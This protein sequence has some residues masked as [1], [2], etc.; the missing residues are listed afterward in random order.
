M[1]RAVIQYFLL[2][3]SLFTPVSS[4]YG[5]SLPRPQIISIGVSGGSLTSLETLP[6]WEPLSVKFLVEAGYFTQHTRKQK[7]GRWTHYRC[8]KNCL[9][10][11]FGI[12]VGSFHLDKANTSYLHQTLGLYGRVGWLSGP[13]F[14]GARLGVSAIP[15]YSEAFGMQVTVGPELWVRLF[16]HLWLVVQVEYGLL[17]WFT[18]KPLP[19]HIFSL[20]GGLMFRI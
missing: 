3:G 6:G 18:S 17:G 1:K 10:Y 4:A 2:L 11:G 14:L 8:F 13:L 19:M 9:A 5:Y 7:F 16:S 15:V 20:R 12:H